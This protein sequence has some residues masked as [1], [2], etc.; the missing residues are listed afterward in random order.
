MQDNQTKY[1]FVVGG[2]ISGVGK[3]ITS[4]S[5]GLILKNR[6]LV[7]TAVKVDPYVNIDAGTSLVMA[8]NYQSIQVIFNGTSYEVF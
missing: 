4:S 6:G 7:V 1:I 5:I 2:V 3:G 8:T